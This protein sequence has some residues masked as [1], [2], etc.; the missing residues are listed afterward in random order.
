LFHAQ[1]PRRQQSRK[2]RAIGI[3]SARGSESERSAFGKIVW[4]ACQ[5][6]FGQGGFCGAVAPVCCV[7]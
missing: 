2:V 5:Q 3:A 7:P 1:A 4:R 6:P